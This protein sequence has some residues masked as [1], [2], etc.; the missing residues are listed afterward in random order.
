MFKSL[1]L[2]KSEA[3]FSA[4][5]VDTDDAQLPDGDVLARVDYSTLNY[6]D[7][8]AITNKAPVVRAWPMVAGIDGA[9]T[10]LESTHASWHIRR[11]L[12]LV[13]MAVT[14]WINPRTCVW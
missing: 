12:Y 13:S 10:V 14:C 8:L 1:Q 4:A 11:S 7:G 6:K 2:A 5:I 9:G 3:G